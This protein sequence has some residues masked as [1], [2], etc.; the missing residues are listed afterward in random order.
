MLVGSGSSEHVFGG[1]M[2]R[3]LRILSSVNFRNSVSCF[4]WYGVNDGGSA[5]SVSSRTALILS[6]KWSDSC[7]AV[8]DGVGGDASLSRRRML[9]SD[10]HNFFGVS[11]VV[12]DATAPISI[13]LLLVQCM[14]LTH[15]NDP[16][17][18]IWITPGPSVT[19]FQQ[20]R[21]ATSLAAVAVEPRTQAS[22]PSNGSKRRSVDVSDMP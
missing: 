19:S 17:S 4:P 5:W 1:N 11:G 15:L 18:A 6:T 20:P 12:G 14:H 2:N 21:L 7:W 10:R 22:N 16:C 8:S 13:L 3:S 9:A